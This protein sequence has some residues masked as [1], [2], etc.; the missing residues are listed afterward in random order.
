VVAFNLV[1]EFDKMGIDVDFV[2]GISG[3][4]LTKTRNLSE[5][6]GFSEKTNLIPVTRNSRVPGSYTATIDSGFLHNLKYVNERLDKSFDLIDFN[7]FPRAED[8]CLPFAAR[9]KRIPA[10][11][12]GGGWIT[13]ETFTEKKK[14]SRVR[15]YYDYFTFRLLRRFFTRIVCNSS[16]LKNKIVEDRLFRNEEI[17]VIPNGID[18]ERFRNSKRIDLQGDPAL[19]FVGRLEHI[20]GVDI[21][22]KSMKSILKQLPRAVLHI[23]GNGTMMN[24]MKIYVGS[25]SLGNKVIF[26]GSI[27]EDLPAYYGSTDICIVPSR[28]DIGPSVILEAMSAGEPIVA[29]RVGGIPELIEDFENGIL[30]DPGTDHIAQSIIELWNDKDLL[31]KISQNNI[32]KA[33]SYCWSKIAVDYLKL[34]KSVL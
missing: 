30:V 19:L 8:I 29:S 23:V 13:Y 17:E 20:K 10:I 18:C 1:R 32:A 27:S 2:F 3:E 7:S 34:Y 12:R 24:Q 14:E 21:L 26:H 9:L 31:G 25:N 5:L 22:L 28:F 11:F 4:Q 33:E 16:F 6:L 15:V